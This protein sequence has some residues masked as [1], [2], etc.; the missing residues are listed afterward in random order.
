MIL[1]DLLRLKP[2]TLIQGCRLMTGGW[3]GRG[4]SLETTGWVID[5][6]YD[7]KNGKYPP[8]KIIQMYTV[9]DDNFSDSTIIKI[10][11]WQDYR[12]LKAQRKLQRVAEKNHKTIE[13]RDST[14]T[15]DSSPD[16]NI[17][18]TAIKYGDIVGLVLGS[19]VITK[20]VCSDN[21]YWGIYIRMLLKETPCWIQ[22]ITLGEKE[23]LGELDII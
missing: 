15:H 7:T 18:M 8:P 3:L 17:K 6:N 2:G 10:S 20:P 4:V 9:P 21:G 12:N 1:K 22:C 5:I 19:Y 16:Y 13:L 11:T 14:R 23:P